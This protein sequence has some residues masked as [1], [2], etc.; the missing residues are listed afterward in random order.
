M[1]LLLHALTVAVV[2]VAIVTVVVVVVFLFAAAVYTTFRFN[3]SKPISMCT[4]KIRLFATVYS[5]ARVCMCVC[6]RTTYLLP[7]RTSDHLKI[8]VTSLIL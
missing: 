6:A 5:R 3:A 1:S 8:S 4:K 2:V 7:A